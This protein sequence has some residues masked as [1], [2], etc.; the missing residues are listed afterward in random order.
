M[1]REVRRRAPRMFPAKTQ[2][3]PNECETTMEPYLQPPSTYELPPDAAS[4]LAKLREMIQRL[5]AGEITPAQFRAFRVP[6]GVYEQREADTYMLRVRFPAGAALPH[7]LRALADVARQYGNGV[8]HVTT[9]QDIQVH[10]VPLDAMHPALTAL[11]AAGL[12]T[13]GGGGNT[14]RNITACH[15]AGVC[16]R[17]V[18]DVAPHAVAV[19]EFLLPDPLSFEL[20]RKFKIA[21]AGCDRDCVGV[22]VND[23]GFLATRRDG[24]DGFVVYAGG[25]MGAH[26]RVGDVLEEFVPATEAHLVAEAV[27][28]VFDRHGN[29][30]NRHRARLRFLV[31]QIGPAAFTEL[32]REQLEEVRKAAPPRRDIRPLSQP[33]EAREGE[34]EAVP[35]EAGQGFAAWRAANVTPQA[36]EGRFVVGINLFLGDIPA[37]TLRGLADVVEAHGEGMLRANQWQNLALRWVAEDELAAVHARLAVLGLA[38]CDPPVLRDLVPCAGASTCKLGICLSRGLAEAVARRLRASDA[39]LDA[40]GELKLFISGCPNSCGRHPV[41]D[42]GLSGAA[43]RVEGRLVPHYA[44]HLGGR[45]A[46]NQT[47]L[48]TQEG[49]IPARNVPDFLADYLAAFVA[50]EE[51]PDFE[52]FVDNGGREKARELLAAHVHVPD[53]TED[54]NYYYDWGA[55]ELFSLAGRGPGECGA[56]VFELIEVDL[57]SAQAAVEEGR[58]FAATVLAAR[59]LLVTRGEQAD[60]AREALELFDRHFVAEGHV[61]SRF[62]ALLDEAL[63]IVGAADAEERFAHRGDEAAALVAAV[64]D[65][66]ERMDDSLRLPPARAEEAAPAPSTPGAT[67]D[68]ERDFRGVA[69]PLNYVKTKLVLEQM[70]PGQVLAV[71][72]D[73]E[74][75]RNVPGSVEADGHE[76]LGTSPEGE[77]TRVVIRKGR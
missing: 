62:G 38:E 70:Q 34:R 33:P 56:G 17:E 54:R 36:Q 12:S 48:G 10:R 40:A 15:D 43:R 53:F 20:P 7:Q 13:K 22:A 73:E 37:D 67:A 27:K 3:L 57:D 52:A 26:S 68:A 32:Y 24:V 76:V 16:P 60:D 47:R 64:R 14:V 77:S 61:D 25:G 30:K 41:A 65:L 21:F 23:V 2:A 49:T 66:H 35:S 39:D 63:G 71:L 45:L 5:K 72:L 6:L 55:E 51:A 42:I 74:G 75:A 50:S 31:E 9:R 29:R 46:A 8:L 11:L 4:D 59:A 58:S 69:C 28:R 44:V 1:G 18:F 19:T